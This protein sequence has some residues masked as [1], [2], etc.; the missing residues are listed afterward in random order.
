MMGV[1]GFMSGPVPQTPR[2]PNFLVVRR[3]VGG[4]EYAEIPTAVELGLV[5]TEQWRTKAAEEAGIRAVIAGWFEIPTDSFEFH[6]GREIPE[7]S[8]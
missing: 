8:R 5:R 3:W 2:R 1:A 7:P 4:V 6:F